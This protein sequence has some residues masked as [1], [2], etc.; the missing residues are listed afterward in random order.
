MDSGKILDGL[1]VKATGGFYYVEAAQVIYECKARGAFRRQGDSPLV[2]DRVKIT[3]PADGY[4]S[5]DSIYPRKNKL[6]RPPLAN[7]DN[8][9]IVCSTVDPAPN[10]TVIDKMTAAAVHNNITPVIVI[11]KSDLSDGEEISK[12]YA[13]AGFRVFNYSNNNP[14]SAL[15]VKELLKGSISAFTGNTGVGKSTL[16]NVLFPELNLQ[17]GDISKKLGRGRHTTR[18]VELFKTGDGYVADTPGF[19]T[20]DLEKYDM[21]DKDNLQYCFPEFSQYLGECR[22]ASCAHI[23]EKD[24]AVIE[25]V[26]NGEI[27][28]SRH[29]SYSLM[30]NELKDIK[31]WEK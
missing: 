1:L 11:S 18:T 3:V 31:P 2:G 9:I 22:F 12:I 29:N 8:L 19:S 28:E 30:Y 27:P 10:T 24:C 13:K 21:A 15:P 7:L 25:A 20:I 23:C 6:T 14:Q 4:C 16:L 26:K 17:T 5:V